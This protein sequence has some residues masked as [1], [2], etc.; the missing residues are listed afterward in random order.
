MRTGKCLACKAKVGRSVER[1][2]EA[3]AVGP[4]SPC[5]P[6]PIAVSTFGC[7][8]SPGCQKITRNILYSSQMNTQ[9]I[10]LHRHEYSILLEDLRS[11]GEN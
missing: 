4:V 5:Y 10:S 7:E 11:Q 9:G 6:L 2:M 1:R 8:I 3:T